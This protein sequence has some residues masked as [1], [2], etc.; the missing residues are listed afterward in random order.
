MLLKNIVSSMFVL[1]VK[2]HFKHAFD[3]IK[4]CYKC[5]CAVILIIIFNP[6]V[7]AFSLLLLKFKRKLVLFFFFFNI[8]VVFLSRKSV[9]LLSIFYNRTKSI[10]PLFFINT[11]IFKSLEQFLICLFSFCKFLSLHVFK[12]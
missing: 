8:L 2:G 6:V 4:G 7:F 5:V 9:R 11:F 3:I 12:T 1:L 10:L